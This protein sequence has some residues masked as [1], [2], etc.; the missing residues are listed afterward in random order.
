V[1]NECRLLEFESNSLKAEIRSMETEI[2]T[3]SSCYSFLLELVSLDKQKI[4]TNE[5]DEYWDKQF[6]H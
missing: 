4:I 6:K 5:I 1:D 3:L 2:N